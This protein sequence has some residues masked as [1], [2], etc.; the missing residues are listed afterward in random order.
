MKSTSFSKFL[1]IFP[2]LI[3]PIQSTVLGQ[4]ADAAADSTVTY[5]ASYFAQFSPVS[6]NDMLDRIPGIELALQGGDSDP[7]SRRFRGGNR[8]LG[9][10]SQILIDGKRLAGKAN[11]ARSQLNRITANEVDYIEIV[12]GTSSE[13]DVQNSGQLI[14]IVLLESASRSSY[15][16]ELGM[17][18]FQDGTVKPEGTLSLTGQSGRFNYL[19]SADMAP[20]YRIENT[21]ELSM[22]PDLSFNEIIK[23]DRK[24]EQTNYSFNSNLNWDFENGDRLA[25]NLLY[26]ESD[27]PAK[28]FREITDYNG[29]IPAVSYER[30]RI[31][32][33]AYNWE[34]GGDYERNFNNGAKYKFLFIVNDK[35]GDTT[36]ERFNF[37]KLGDVENK[38][39]FL[40]NSGGYQEKIVR[41]SYTW[42]VAQDQGLELGIEGA[43]TTQDSALLLGLPLGGNPSSRHGGLT[44][45]NL[46]NAISTVEEIRYEGFAVHNWRINPRMSLE[47]SLVAEYSE[48]EQTG[49]IYNKRD[50]DFLKPKFDFR[51]DISNST[52]FRFTLEK[53]VSQ[54]TFT[55]FSANTNERDED[56]DTIAGNPEIKQQQSWRYTTYLDYRLPNDGGV[57]NAR[58]FYYDFE[59]DI[60]RIDISPS[61]SQLESMNGNVGDGKVVGLNVNAS[62]RLAMVNLPQALV[63]AG[64][65][66]Q[67]SKIFDP[68]IDDHRKVVPF[69]RGSFNVGF[70]H[71]VSRWGLNYGINYS[72]R[73]DGNRA[74]W[75]IDNI[76][77]IGSPSNLMTFV[78]KS[79]W[80]GLTFRLE[81]INMRD[82][83]RKTERRRYAGYFRDDVLKEIERFY[84]T[85][86]VR[87]TFKVRGTF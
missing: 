51:Y 16:V 79:G 15:G 38:N 10:S 54:L 27:P 41:T 26:G 32:S 81:I 5:P 7:L 30:E 8:G 48:I 71:D 57:I 58:L 12:R 44:A 9:G 20:W 66:V 40:D 50:F 17:R 72:D 13:L 1:S 65:L 53:D 55:D 4:E 22:H 18:H 33:E 77:Y 2:L 68:L 36:R 64:F 80:R 25:L 46:P 73:I 74:F 6:V 31:P 69:D 75:D 42:N 21:E 56:Q 29:S 78:E 23:L 84:T 67:D 47:S 35:V 24:V 87:Y 3:L 14:N 59:D 85:D 39:L 52:Q 82:H 76:F 34:I 11:E 37:L 43:Q 49:D 61:L 86:G 60:G 19:V 62:I 28:L 70:R 45:V 83:V 63:T